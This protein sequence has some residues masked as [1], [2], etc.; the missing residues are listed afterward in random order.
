LEEVEMKE[1]VREWSVYE[2]SS[3]ENRLG[4][5]AMMSPLCEPPMG[6]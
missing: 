1:T 2:M 4:F 6:E 3:T 5:Q